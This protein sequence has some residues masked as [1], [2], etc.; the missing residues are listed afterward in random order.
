MYDMQ[1]DNIDLSRFRAAGANFGGPIGAPTRVRQ[2]TLEAR[3]IL[4][5]A[6]RLPPVGRRT[7]PALVR[8]DTKLQAVQRASTKLSIN[9][10]SSSGHLLQE[11]PVCPRPHPGAGSFGRAP[12]LTRARGGLPRVPHPAGSGTRAASS[13]SAGRTRSSWSSSLTTAPSGCT[14][15]TAR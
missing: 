12:L 7:R 4:L 15:C 13:A 9:I 11:I 3:D 8:D 14:T 1:W 5:T 6:A 10:Y 2:P